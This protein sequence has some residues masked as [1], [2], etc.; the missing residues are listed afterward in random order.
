MCVKQRREQYLT[1]RN[2]SLSE[3]FCYGD[4]GDEGDD[5]DDDDDCHFMPWNKFGQRR[6][7]RKAACPFF[8]YPS[9]LS[10][11]LITDAPPTE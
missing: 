7:N 4:D 1:Q 3:S 5:D 8:F 2:C 10:Y 11:R 6:N 9:Q